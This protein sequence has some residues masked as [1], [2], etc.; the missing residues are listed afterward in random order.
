MIGIGILLGYQYLEHQ[1]EEQKRVMESARQVA[2]KAAAAIDRERAKH[3]A[4]MAKYG[5]GVEPWH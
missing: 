2:A 3:E 1:L 4:A 5:P